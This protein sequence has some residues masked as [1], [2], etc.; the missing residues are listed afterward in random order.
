M[1]D[2]LSVELEI[3]DDRADVVLSKTKQKL[4]EFV[5]DVE[6]KQP[7]IRFSVPGQSFIDLDK[8]ENR[9]RTT[10]EQFNAIASLRLNNGQ[11]GS[12]TRDIVSA[13]ERSRQLAADIAG[14]KAELAN[15][16]RKSSIAFLTDELKAAQMEADRL[17]R[18]LDLV[19]GQGVPGQRSGGSLSPGAIAQGRLNLARQ[20]ADVFTSAAMG[21]NP[22]MIAIQ[23]GPQILDAMATSGIQFSRA[24]VLSAGAIG[25]IAV[26][27]YAVVKWS[28][29]AREEAERRLKVEEKI[30]GA[31]NRQ[32]LAGKDFLTN[33]EKL[34]K[35][36]AQDRE[37][38]RFLG[39]GSIGDLRQR[40]A[41]LRQLHDFGSNNYDVVR[42]KDG[43]PETV[44]TE[45]AQ[46]RVQEMLAL[47]AEI[48]SRQAQGIEKSDAAFQQRWD[49]WKSSQEN[50]VKSIK[51][52]QEEQEKWNRKVE[53][54]KEKIES[55][56]EKWRSA[57]DSLY[58]RA[59]TNNPFALFLQRSATDAEKLRE[60]LKGLPPELQKTALA[61]K[62]AA[63]SKELFSL[64]LETALS[65]QSLK[66]NADRFRDP[67]A[68]E[69]ANRRFL[70][71]NPNYLFLKEQEFESRIRDPRDPASLAGMSFDEF[72]RND[73]QERTGTGIN[74]TLRSQYD[75]LFGRARTPE[76]LAE[77]NKRFAALGQGVDAKDL[78]GDVR[79]KL[80]DA[81]L[82]EA[83]RMEMYEKTAA[84]SRK[85]MN[86]YLKNISQHI[87]KLNLAAEK[88][89]IDGV[90]K[91]V[92]IIVKEQ[93]ADGSVKKVTG[94]TSSDV[95]D[96][97][98]TGLQIAGGSNR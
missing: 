26:A 81:N 93:A 27:G 80:I 54:G 9:A 17:D 63:E 35:S 30:Q 61:M 57:F 10:A 6:K 12:L 78:S 21:M 65:V 34:E 74:N 67:Y 33:Y 60:S 64:K 88:G 98:F 3:K 18:K 39:K 47:K 55:L 92:E 90:N 8:I 19:T 87:D 24:M 50:V 66:S 73:L 37:F 79:N 76:E 40:Y 41:D 77:A 97:Y 7:Q 11:I 96:Y 69:R 13:H 28:Q 91:A 82:Q 16:N 51:D 56:K 95:A 1:N 94:A 52:A 2:V 22:T 53:E 75:A 14:I 43:Q 86:G 62:A 15:P 46:R 4:E 89:G 71:N 44:L 32:I 25:T 23:Q 29:S 20:G 49:S 31:I 68:Q 38:S 45:A 83:A 36:Q 72:I 48:E 85:E 58:Q 84:E 42:G 70:E 59:N 5:R